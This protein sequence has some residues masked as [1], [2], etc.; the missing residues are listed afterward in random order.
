MKS[1]CIYCPSSVFYYH[2]AE[3]GASKVERHELLHQPYD[4]FCRSNVQEE[5]ACLT[6]EHL[7]LRHL[8]FCVLV[9]IRKRFLF[10]LQP[11]LLEKDVLFTCLL[12]RLVRHMV[13]H[14]FGDEQ[15]PDK[16]SEY[17]I[18]LYLDL[19]H[20]YYSGTGAATVSANNKSP[21]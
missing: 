7:R 20:N 12:C 6:G 11:S 15:I 4:K 17:Y 5:Q 2:Y 3:N 19:F 16:S 1:N 8:I 18:C 13:F 21:S 9:E 10:R 14:A